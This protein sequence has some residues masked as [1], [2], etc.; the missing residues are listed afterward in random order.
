[1]VAYTR[2]DMKHIGISGKEHVFRTDETV[3]DKLWVCGAVVGHRVRR[4]SPQSPSAPPTGLFPPAAGPTS[5][6]RFCSNRHLWG[7]ESRTAD[8]GYSSNSLA[9]F[10]KLLA[11]VQKNYSAWGVTWLELANQK[12]AGIN[13]DLCASLHKLR[14][15]AGTLGA[16]ELAAVA[17][18]AGG[19]V[20]GG[21]VLPLETVQRV[22]RVLHCWLTSTTTCPYRCR[23]RQRC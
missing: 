6:P 14:G 10:K 23:M 16:T 18:Q 22:A 13:A 11:L 3:R 1:M 15:S 5:W 20:L 4:A 12:G 9:L 8:L 17:R 21:T 2:P 19:A 7:D